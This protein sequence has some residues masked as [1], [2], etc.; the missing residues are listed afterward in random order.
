[1]VQA[2]AISLIPSLLRNENLTS[3]QALNL[4]HRPILPSCLHHRQSRDL[5]QSP[6]GKGRG[7]QGSTVSSVAYLLVVSSCV[8]LPRVAPL[9]VEL[10]YSSL[11]V[12]NLVNS[13]EPL[14]FIIFFCLCKPYHRPDPS[15]HH[16]QP[17]S[18]PSEYHQKPIKP[19]TSHPPCPS[20]PRNKASKEEQQTR[21]PSRLEIAVATA[22]ETRKK[23][24]AP[25]PKGQP[26]RRQP[27]IA[28]PAAVIPHQR[29]QA[30]ASMEMRRRTRTR[31]EEERSNFVAARSC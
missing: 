10:V 23:I 7:C 9:L 6:K 11:S 19:A 20:Q 5:S 14:L 13:C 15:L 8:G 22:L 27:P 24:T 12:T 25:P 2:Q 17:C 3:T 16:R 1:M 28:C 26:N 31:N 18:L 21:H 4:P 30:P 29:G